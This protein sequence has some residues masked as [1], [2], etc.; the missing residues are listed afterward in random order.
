MYFFYTPIVDNTTAGAEDLILWFNG[1]PGCSSLGGAFTENG[2]FNLGVSETTNYTIAK[3]NPYAWRNFTNVLYIESPIGT[4]FSF[5]S[6]TRI[7]DAHGFADELLSWFKNWL[8]IFP[9]AKKWKLHLVG[10]SYASFYTI[11]GLDKFM[12]AGLNVAGMGE[13]PTQG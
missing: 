13:H 7:K 3:V 5:P 12:D 2:P 8:E 6:E 11:Y 10:E 1:G 9:E 4:G